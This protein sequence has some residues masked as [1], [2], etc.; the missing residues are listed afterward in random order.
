VRDRDQVKL[1]AEIGCSH[2][3]EISRAKYLAELAA[4]HGASY[5]KFQKRNPKECIPQSIADKPHP[6]PAFAYGDTYLKHRRALEL[7]LQQ[8]EELKRHC[9]SLG[10]GYSSSVWD[11]TSA[12]EI[13][14]LEPDYIKIPSACCMHFGLIDHV[15]SL[16]HCP[17]HVSVGMTSSEELSALIG[18]Y[19]KHLGDRIVLYQC[20]AEYPARVDHLDVSAIT[21]LIDQCQPDDCR[22][23]HVGFSNHSLSIGADLAAVALGA[24]WIEHHFIDNRAFRHTDAACSLCPNEFS[25][26]RRL[27]MEAVMSMSPKRSLSKEEER[28]R[29]KLRY[30]EQE[31]RCD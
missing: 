22:L 25:V 16:S 20:T 12:D 18:N 3:G 4:R 1:V 21:G 10:V 6:N 7:S 15:L 26:L 17:I 27:S 5:V 8:H 30:Y 19:K 13:I 23:P 14:S 29:S 9:E 2:A 11:F 31:A 28:Q 24:T